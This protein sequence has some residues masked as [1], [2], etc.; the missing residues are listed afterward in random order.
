VEHFND[1]MTYCANDVLT[2]HQIYQV[3]LP[4]F[5]DKCPHP[6]SFAGML[7]MGRGFLTTSESWDKF[8]VSAEETYRTEADEIEKDLNRFAEEALTLLEGG[9]WKD[10]LWLRNLD[11]TLP[12]ERSR[13]LKGFP[14][15]YRYVQST[16]LHFMD[17]KHYA[18]LYLQ[19]YV[20][21]SNQIR[22]NY[23]I[24]TSCSISIKDEMGW[25]SSSLESE[26]RMVVPS[27]YRRNRETKD[28]IHGFSYGS[29][30]E[31]L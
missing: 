28:Q 14:K 4:K 8:L 3:V 21:Y 22:Q 17:L 1:L 25:L 23:N 31:G 27:T 7:E 20:G 16:F 30:R 11:W 5:L 13:K 12:S 24:E 19:R 15:W 10:D 9:K 26:I 6:V 18:H 29:F 2:T